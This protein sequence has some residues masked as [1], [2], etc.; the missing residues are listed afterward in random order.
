M[1]GNSANSYAQMRAGSLSGPD[2]SFQKQSAGSKTQTV[3]PHMASTFGT[4]NQATRRMRT[5]GPNY[6]GPGSGIDFG[7][8]PNPNQMGGM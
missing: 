6:L 2:F 7:A 4:R 3:E 8:S 1:N 5:E